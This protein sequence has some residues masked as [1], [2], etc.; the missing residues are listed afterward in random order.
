M[1]GPGDIAL[2]KWTK[3]PTLLK[4]VFAMGGG[5]RDEVKR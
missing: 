2:N 3:P 1:P 4:L 5:V